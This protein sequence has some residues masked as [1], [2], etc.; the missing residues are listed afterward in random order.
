MKRFY[1]FIAT[2][3]VVS[4]CEED[5]S[6]CS[7]GTETEQVSNIVWLDKSI[8]H[9]LTALDTVPWYDYSYNKS[10][11]LQ[12]S[13]FRDGGMVYVAGQLLPTVI[14]GDQRWTTMDYKGYLH[15]SNLSEWDNVM[16]GVA[17]S[18]DSTVYYSYNLAM[19]LNNT[20]T[21]A[22]FYSPAGLEE[23]SSWRIPSWEDEN[24]LHHLA[25]GN[26]T[27]I[28]T[29]LNP[30]TRGM[31]YHTYSSYYIPTASIIPCV[32]A[33]NESV[34]WNSEYHDPV[35]N[36]NGSVSGPDGTWHLTAMN[37]TNHTYLFQ[38]QLMMPYAP[39]RLVQNVRPIE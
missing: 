23:T 14:I 28:N 27:L 8:K 17:T 9:D 5:L 4:G 1:I 35:V 18:S 34:H 31:I 39:I 2:L 22:N 33:A 26:E 13:S 37:G 10:A 19:T 7:E 16:Y 20:I 38:F 36:A 24:H 11:S 29:W 30:L 21:M 15:D 12:T 6:L 32:F 25:N 3:L